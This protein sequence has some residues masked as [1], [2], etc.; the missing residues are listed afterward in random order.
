M[1]SGSSLKTALSPRLSCP[2][3][4]T[5]QHHIRQGL[6]PTAHHNAQPLRMYALLC[7][8]PA[9][10]RPTSVC[11]MFINHDEP[12]EPQNTS[13][14]PSSLAF[15]TL[16][17][18]GHSSPLLPSPGQ[19]PEAITIPALCLPLWPLQSQIQPTHDHSS[20]ETSP[21]DTALSPPPP[22]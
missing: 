7:Q 19:N 21:L 22:K 11:W 13:D 15:S 17:L 12:P 18:L 9:R 2:S 10:R 5:Q 20:F 6:P 16:P 3:E 8:N 4:P 14:S 1:R